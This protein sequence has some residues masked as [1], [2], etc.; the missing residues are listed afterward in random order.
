MAGHAIVDWLFMLGLLGIGVALIIGVAMRF[1]TAAGATMYIADVD[2]SL[3][4][5]NNPVVDD[6]LVGAIV[7]IVLVSTSR[8][9]LGPRSRWKAP[10][11]SRRSPS[12]GNHA[13][14]RPTATCSSGQVAVS[15]RVCSGGSSQGSPVDTPR[16]DGAAR[17]V[18]LE[19]EGPPQPGRAPA[20][21]AQAAL[22]AR[23]R[24]ADAIVRDGEPQLAS[25]HHHLDL[26]PLGRGVPGHVG[27]GLPQH[28]QQLL[29]DRG[30][31]AVS[32]GPSSRTSGAKPSTGAYS[33]T[34]VRISARRELLLTV[35]QLEDGGRGCP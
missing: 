30:S 1:A 3:P 14:R 13:D 34:R 11:W 15:C 5:E 20:G 12:C 17:L 29:A 33:R 10:S 8:R 32:I 22:A 25:A 16:Q 6:H 18:G 23:G 35:L 28:R 4:L 24:E 21:V 9:H 31:T 7:M 26:G 2:A 27:Q 19:L